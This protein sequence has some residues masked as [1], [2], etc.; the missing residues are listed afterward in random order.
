MKNEHLVPPIIVDLVNKLNDTKLRDS[1]RFN[2]IE[3]IEATKNYCEQAL[4]KLLK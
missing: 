1:E 4:L 2:Y 3:R